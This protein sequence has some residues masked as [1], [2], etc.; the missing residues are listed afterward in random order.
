[1][2][3]S[4]VAAAVVGVGMGFLGASPLWAQRAATS[5]SIPSGVALV[6]VASITMNSQ[7]VKQSIEAMKAQ[8][9]QSAATLKKE[10]DSGNAITEQVRKL[11]PGPERKKAE[12]D[13]MKKRADFELHGKRLRDEAADGEAKVYHAL[14]RE[15]REELAR[16]AAATGVPLILRYEP[17][18]ADFPDRQSVAA[19]IEKLVVYQRDADVTPQVL[20]ELN[21]RA[22]SGGTSR[23]PA[24]AKGVQR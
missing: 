9:E 11:P 14:A 8:Y 4:S 17:S 23:A 13:L 5:S 6:D 24:P 1:M 7:R 12:Q 19:E 3:K 10:S 21:R 20:G 22:P 15:L 2:S 18:P 16:Y